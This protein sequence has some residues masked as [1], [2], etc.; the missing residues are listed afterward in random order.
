LQSLRPR[1]PQRLVLAVPVAPT[2]VLDKLRADADEIA[3]LEEPRSFD[4]LGQFYSDFRRE[5]GDR[6]VI[7]VLAKFSENVG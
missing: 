6:E 7:D 4:A 3:C 2:G 1:A 5:V